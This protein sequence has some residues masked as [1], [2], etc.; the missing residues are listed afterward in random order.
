MATSYCMRRRANGNLAVLGRSHNAGSAWV[1][2]T[3]LA[4]AEWLHFK[5]GGI[6][7]PRPA[8][9]RVLFSVLVGVSDFGRFPR[10]DIT[11]AEQVAHGGPCGCLAVGLPLGFTSGEGGVGGGLRYTAWTGA[12]QTVGGGGTAG[13]SARALCARPTAHLWRRTDAHRPTHGSRLAPASRR[14]CAKDAPWRLPQ[15]AGAQPR[16]PGW[17]TIAKCRSS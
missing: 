3:S 8:P 11:P 17:P 15:G 1:L 16:K 12:R 9:A 5:C 7:S 4:G 14:P 6:Q 13:L 10:G 2:G